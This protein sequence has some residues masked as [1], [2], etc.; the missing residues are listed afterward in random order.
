MKAATAKKLIVRI[1]APLGCKFTSSHIVYRSSCA[2]DVMSI[3][4]SRFSR[5]RVAV[6]KEANR[7]R[8]LRR[9]LD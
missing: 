1:E 7:F 6:V 9:R 4:K 3:T 2:R 5:L 8:V